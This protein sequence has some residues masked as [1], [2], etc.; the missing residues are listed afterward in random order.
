MCKQARR[1][2]HR[3]HAL[4]QAAAL[5]YKINMAMASYYSSIELMHINECLITSM[6]LTGI[7]TLTKLPFKLY[8]HIQPPYDY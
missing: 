5:A 7:I 2:K 6:E 1:M 3:R 4:I 8:D